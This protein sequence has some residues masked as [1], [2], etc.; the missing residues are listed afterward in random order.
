MDQIHEP[1]VAPGEHLVNEHD[2]ERGREEEKDEKP[3]ENGVGVQLL[4]EPPDV[5]G[6][7]GV[8]DVGFQNRDVEI[9]RHQ[10]T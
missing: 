3:A 2:V 4:V 10:N 1:G 8:G 5:G 9:D 6:D 7:G